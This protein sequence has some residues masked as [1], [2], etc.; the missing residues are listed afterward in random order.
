MLTAYRAR[1]IVTMDPACPEVRDGAVL[2]EDGRIAAVV[3]WREAAGEP[4]RDLGP[5]TLA[6][7]LINAHT[8]LELSHLAGKVPA[9]Q[10][11]AEWADG[12]FAAMRTHR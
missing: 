1:R 3:P 12:L 5:V 4:C 2:V 9:G 10:G 8:H 6:P 11:F 7:G